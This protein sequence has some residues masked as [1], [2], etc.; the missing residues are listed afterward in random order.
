MSVASPQSVYFIGIGGIGMSALA[1]YFNRIGAE[2]GG[3]DLHQ[4]PLTRELER[5]GIEVHYEARPEH[6]P[7]HVDLVIYTPA[8]P[9]DFPELVEVRTQGLRLVKRAEA[10]GIISQRHRTLAVSGTHGKTTTSAMAAY[11]MK[12]ANTD[13]VAFL[14]GISANYDTNYLA[15][16]GEWLVV[17]ADEYDRSF[18][19]LNPEVAVVTFIEPDHMDIYGEASAFEDSF[20]DFISRIHE[21]GVV[22]TKRAI[23]E[24]LKRSLQHVTTQ[25][26]GIEDESADWSA[27]NVTV[28][29]G[30][31]SFD[32]RHHDRYFRGLQLQMPGRHNIENAV[33]AVA[34]TVA[35][36]VSLELV[37]KLL[38][39]F[40]GVQRR[41]EILGKWRG[42]TIISDY[43]HH[44]TEVS[45]AIT[46]ANE[47]F[48]SYRVIGIFQPHLY[49]RTRDFANEFAAALSDLQ[50]VVMLELYPARE[51][52]IEGI[53]SITIFSNI[54]AGKK[55]LV[56][57]SE[58]VDLLR[59][60]DGDILLFMGAGDIDRIARSLLSEQ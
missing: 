9:N 42:A 35:A 18:L 2:V 7:Q 8:V 43:A 15:G 59:V 13:A 46:S 6:I 11:L 23:A 19:Q 27:H 24:Q 47:L 58:V 22:I 54:S 57:S 26:Y 56:D 1:R 49:S 38:G 41:F 30:K 16:S 53:S 40:R 28:I 55:Y 33:A 36:G 51:I 34:A 21:G 52:P 37:V 12:E 45:A 20:H 4:T 44:P 5:E 50:E 31:Y 10:L 60:L 3:Y 32:L 14:G 25:T 29:D 17:E 39:G 48:G